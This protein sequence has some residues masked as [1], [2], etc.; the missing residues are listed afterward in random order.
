MGLFYFAREIKETDLFDTLIVHRRIAELSKVSP[1]CELFARYAYV[2]AFYWKC[3]G[4]RKEKMICSGPRQHLQTN[5]FEHVKV[6]RII[7]RNIVLSLYDNMMKVDFKKKWYGYLNNDKRINE[8][9]I[10]LEFK[11]YIDKDNNYAFELKVPIE[12]CGTGKHWK[13]ILTTT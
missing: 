11:Y 9:L 1:E 5:A 13:T 3:A 8:H 4:V 12:E 10:L 2:P 7:D 6:L